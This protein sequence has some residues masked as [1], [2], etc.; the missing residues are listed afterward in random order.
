MNFT[1]KKAMT[2]RPVKEKKLSVFLTA[3]LCAAVIFVPFIIEGHGYFTFFGDFNV[4]QIPF[5]KMCHEAV[6]SGNIKWSFTTDLGANFIG[7]YSFYLLGSPFF[8]LTIP[9]P[10]D[11]VPYLMGPLLILKF[12]LAAFTAYLYIRRFTKT[13]ASAQIGGLLYA[14]SGFSVYNVFFNH[15]HEPI[16]MFPLL[17][18]SL[19]LL[20]TENRR[21][22]FALAVAA[23]AVMNYFFF[24]GMVVFCIIYYI[25]RI[26]SGAIRFKFKRFL[27]IGFESV[28]GV[29]LA[30]VL[31][32]PSIAAVISN[33][34]VSEF[35]TGWNAITYGKEQIYLNIIECFFFPPDLPARPVF[36]PEADVKWSSLGGWLPVFSMTGVLTV[37]VTKKKSWTKR[38]ITICFIFSMFPILNSAFYAFN[39]A[40]YAR[41]FYMPVL[42]MCLCTVTLF[43]ERD[44][45]FK[46]GFIYTGLIT[47]AFFL[48]IGFFPSKNDD[49]TLTFGLYT[50]DNDG[51]F[52]SRF[53]VTAAIALICLIMTYALLKI[54]KN[55]LK[56]FFRSATVC[57]CIVSVLYSMFFIYSGRMH[58]DD[59]DSVMIDQLI[60]GKVTIPDDK[61]TYRI[62]VYD[63]VDNTAM[64]L[65]YSSINA[66]HSVVPSSIMEFYDSIGIERNVGSRPSTKYASLRPFLS[67]KY[68]LNPV[69]AESFINAKG[70]TR[71]P[72]YKYLDTDGGY[73]IYENENYIPYGFSYDY[74]ISES[75]YYSLSESDRS[76]MLLKAIVLNSKQV[77]EYGKLMK[78]INDEEDTDD[79]LPPENEESEN[80]IT[81]E[82][83]EKSEFVKELEKNCADR[84][85]TASTSFITD[86]DGFTATVSREKESL[87]FFS[88]PYD[89]GFSATVNGEKAEILKVNIGF[90]AVKVGKGTSE[91]RFDYKTPMLSLGLKVS[92]AAAVIFIAYFVICSVYFKRRPSSEYYTEG[93][94][95]I[96]K[97]H[98]EDLLDAA[99]SFDSTALEPEFEYDLLD[100]IPD[101]GSAAD[102]EKNSYL[103][104]FSI[105][106]DAFNDDKD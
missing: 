44:A 103:G 45:D 106:T 92:G 14:F 34:R 98:K 89:E 5:Y 93:E 96:K 87:V 56:A 2:L 12:A 13:A 72:D 15:F 104:G 67:V 57:V 7:S 75:D 18:L 28:L 81:E 27:V 73:Y 19:E 97:W 99:A 31:L 35:L 66:F 80:L 59:I 8:W 52:K 85:E 42:I 61:S 51:L 62:D 63:G 58:S 21:G 76:S 17:L 69:N 25:V 50:Q 94:D 77:N 16:I 95:L 9:F 102:N 24:F 36:F 64:F 68:L 37:L 39:S 1:D 30:A 74:Y 91:I 23:S 38:L 55:S 41:W 4:Q 65:G 101:I 79:V 6:R 60:E 20:I 22:V 53:F 49:G 83:T 86:N 29:S 71:M 32:L 33:S 100:D 3:L 90:M 105:D 26:W 43:E 82:Q 47:L 10:T 88:V 78:N 11:M 54:R 46:P 84:R 70:E 48:V 40:Y